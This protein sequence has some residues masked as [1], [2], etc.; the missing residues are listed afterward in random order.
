MRQI[1]DQRRLVESEGIV[2]SVMRG[3][4][5]R[6]HFENMPR[7]QRMFGRLL[8]FF[9]L[10]GRGNSN[11]LEIYV[12]RFEVGLLRLPAGFDGFRILFV[13]DMHIDRADELTEKIAESVRSVDFDLCVLGGDYSTKHGWMER[14]DNSNL[15]KIIRILTAK[16]RTI[17]VLG[18]HDIYSIGAFLEE[19]GVEMLVNENICIE[20]NS[21]RMFIAGIDDCHYFGS[22]DIRLAGEGIADDVC[23]IMISHS[24][25]RLRQAAGAGYDLYLA[26]HTH[27]GQ[28][29]LPGGMQIVRGASMRRKYLRGRWQY[30]DMKGYTSSGAGTSGIAVRFF[31]RPEIAL[32]TLRQNCHWYKLFHNN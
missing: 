9:H 20:N 12:N 5:G 31:C 29:C 8:D 32:I 14:V 7:L 13:T 4:R 26:G 1:S 28:V 3:W 25:E 24:P 22:D 17:G 18:N 21:D 27:G 6:F 16:G 15:E 2:H 11:T 10:T 19:L 30:K 23:K